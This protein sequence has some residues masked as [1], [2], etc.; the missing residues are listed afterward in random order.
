MSVVVA[1]ATW[2]GSIPVMAEVG[3]IGW[4]YMIASR[5]QSNGKCVCM[6]AKVFFN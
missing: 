1:F 5:E 3:K 2:I 6:K 4:E